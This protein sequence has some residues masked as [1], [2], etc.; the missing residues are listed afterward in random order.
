[1][2]D[3]TRAISRHQFSVGFPIST[4]L[5]TRCSRRRIQESGNESDDRMMTARREENATRIGTRSW[6][7]ASR[8]KLLGI[9]ADIYCWLRKRGGIQM[10]DE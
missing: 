9:A 4:D 3:Q 1:M 2:Y 7:T 5:P 10:Y 6:D 8:G